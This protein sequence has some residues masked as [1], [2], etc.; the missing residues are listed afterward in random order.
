MT[1]GCCNIKTIL[2]GVLVVLFIS[3][4]SSGQSIAQSPPGKIK[5]FY[6]ALSAVQQKSFYINET[7]EFYTHNGF[8]Y[9]WLLK[10][11]K[12]NFQIL[13]NYLNQC[14]DLGL[15]Q[16]NYSIQYSSNPDNTLSSPASEED[17]ISA[18]I[19]ITDA[20]IHFFHDVAEGNQP[21]DLL[22]N[23]LN[24]SPDCNNIGSTLL[25]YLNA[26]KFAFLLN[27]LQPQEKIYES[28]KNKLHFFEQIISVD[29]FKDE[30]VKSIKLQ[31]NNKPLLKRLYQLGF[32]ASDT[33]TLDAAQIKNKIKEIRNTFN[34]A[35]DGELSYAIIEMLNVPISARITEL[36]S[37][38]NT[39]RWIS[40]IKKSEKH[41]I[42]VNIPSTTLQLYEHEKIVLESKI[43]AGKKSTPTPTLCSKINEV[44]LYPYWNVPNKIATSELLPAIKKNPKFLEENNYQVLDKQAKIIDPS[45]VNWQALSKKNF[46]YTIRQSTGCDNSLGLV[47]LNFYNPYTVYLHDTPFKNFFNFKNRFFSHGCMRVEKAFDVA[48]Y[49]LKNNSITI[50]TLIQKGCLENQNPITIGA[51][52]IIPLFVIYH[53]AWADS[54]A[55]VRFYPDVYKKFNSAKN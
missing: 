32:L 55:T 11:N 1:E 7:K 54:A 24:Y 21:E 40:C 50:D 19:V 35:E 49:V 43:V 6:A 45:D 3:V 23:G 20:A 33:E 51:S 42:V 16:N 44:I 48:R 30:Q 29:S 12:P 8:T 13:L 46:P 47:K 17:S 9:A 2:Y 31:P 26:G 25:T 14:A 4:F 52:E 41:I 28:L 10:Q 39:L 36:K 37:A 27:D 53:T 5:K 15:E 22:Y 34:Q 18:D 38:L